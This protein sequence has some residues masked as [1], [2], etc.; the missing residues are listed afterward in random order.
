MGT[1][2]TTNDSR[3]ARVRVDSQQTSFEANTQFRFFDEIEIP[4]T[5]DYQVVYKV[6]AVNPFILFSRVLSFYQGGATY[7]IYADDGSHTVPGTLADSG[8]IG[9]ANG[10][11]TTSELPAHPETTI[12]LQKAEGSGI[13]VPGS[14]PRTGTSVRAGTNTQQSSGSLA[15]DSV[16]LGFPANFSGWIVIQ[17]IVDVN[18]DSLGEYELYFEERFPE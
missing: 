12:S 9:P 17:K 3:T 14:V 8:W 1:L 13:F 5:N 2:K 7:R 11:L 10:D 6:S 18:Q 16:R 15:A 4:A